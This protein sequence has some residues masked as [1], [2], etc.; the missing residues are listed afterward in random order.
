M[1]DRV[2]ENLRFIMNE[3]SPVKAMVLVDRR[4]HQPAHGEA[5]VGG[6]GFGERLE[7]AV[8]L[9]ELKAVRLDVAGIEELHRPDRPGEVGDGLD[10]LRAGEDTP[11]PHRVDGRLGGDPAG[12][13]GG[14][15]LLLVAAGGGQVAR[16]A[17]PDAAVGDGG[18]EPR[19]R[20]AD[21][22]AER[23]GV[24]VME[25]AVDVAVDVDD[26]LRLR[27]RWS[28]PTGRLRA[29]RWR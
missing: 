19:E 7:R 2:D 24:G 10:R 29:C 8:V 5:H 13:E 27:S 22:A 17:D 9:D 28:S 21:V 1:L 18:E 6:A 14:P 3:P 20:R 26:R 25:D 11:L 16:P 23:R 15:F 12:T 4:R